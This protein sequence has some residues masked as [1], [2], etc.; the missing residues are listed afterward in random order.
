MDGNDWVLVI[1][2][3][4]T[5]VGAL[6]TAAVSVIRAL[7]DN[8]AATRESAEA[9]RA[10]VAQVAGDAPTITDPL[11]ALAQVEAIIEAI[12]IGKPGT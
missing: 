10:R 1:G 12:K 2:A 7:R 6:A 11:E 5:L 4:V 8:T 9:V 3:L